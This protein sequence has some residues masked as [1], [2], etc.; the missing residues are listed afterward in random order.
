MA[1]WE[2]IYIAATAVDLPPVV[3]VPDAVAD[4]R[5]PAKLADRTMQRSVAVAPPDV[6][7][8]AYAVRAARSA[9]AGSGYDFDDVGLFVHT[10]VLDPSPRMSNPASWLE[11]ELGQ[12]GFRDLAQVMHGCDGVMSG[13]RWAAA[14]LTADHERPAALLTAAESWQP[15][16][17][18][19]RW[20]ADPDI[21]LGDGGAALVVSRERGI[22]R[23]LATA[24]YTQPALEGAHRGPRVFG[25]GVGLP[26]KLSERSRAFYATSD[27]TRDDAWKMRSAGITVVIDRVLAYG[28][29]ERERIA[30][31]VLPFNGRHVLEE[32]YFPYLGGI[33][34]ARSSEDRG[35]EV[36]HLGGADPIAALH[37]ALES[38]ELS[39]GDLAVVYSEGV[40]IVQ[41]AAL[42]EIV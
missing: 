13:M 11:R 29:V 4:G 15:T 1:R 32:D 33:A 37:V 19:D 14:H 27:I 20:T 9:L 26:V 12:G 16:E 35:R 41:S 21:P 42:V 30:R 31:I 7:P 10:S 34:P 5:Y 22:A 24:T 3:T 6:S 8:G 39:S 17:V 28:G 18:I 40:G 38:G 2:N 23:L 25:H 36:G